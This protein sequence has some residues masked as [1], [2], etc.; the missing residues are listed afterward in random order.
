M[1]RRSKHSFPTKYMLLILSGLCVLIMFVSF[2]LNLSGGPLNTVAGYVFTPMQKGINSVGNWFVSRADE[3]KSLKN[4]TKENEELQAQ[5]DELTAELNTVKLEQY[6]L[7]SLRE[8]FQLDQKYP[9]YKKV[10]ARI[11]GSDSSN[12]FNTFVIDKGTKD[13]IEKDM[14]VIAG[15]GLVGIVIDVGP[16]YAKVR[17]IIDDANNVSGMTLSTT[18]RCNVNGNLESMNENQVIEFSNLKCDENVIGPGE[19]LVTSNISDKYLEG[20]LIGYI[21]SIKRDSNNLTY[22]GTVTP[23]VDFKHLQEVLVIL[24]KKQSAK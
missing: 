3:L 19:Q 17:S 24:D 23:A 12:W 10:A 16:N 2:T 5:V 15:S 13:G 21:S 18:D 11:I 6:E 1:K 7:D 9:S 14:N 4:V 8:L 20:I 22:S